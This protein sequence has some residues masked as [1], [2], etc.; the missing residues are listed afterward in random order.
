MLLLVIVP[1]LL[2]ATKLLGVDLVHFGVLVVLNI[3]IGLIHP[4]FGM[5][6]V[7]KVLIASTIGEMCSK[8]GRFC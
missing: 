1:M 4:S 5:L 8:A 6:F 3:M 7:T 2:T